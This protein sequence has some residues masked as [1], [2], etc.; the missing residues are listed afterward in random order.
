MYLPFATW[1]LSETVINQLN[2][3]YFDLATEENRIAEDRY[4]QKVEAI[5]DE[6]ERELDAAMRRRQDL[7]T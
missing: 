3:L 1:L 7:L 2:R 6:Y 5:H 4:R